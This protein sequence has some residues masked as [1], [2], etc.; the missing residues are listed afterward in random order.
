MKKELSTMLILITSILTVLILAL[1]F[2]MG[3]VQLDL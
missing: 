3:V 2:F 1:L